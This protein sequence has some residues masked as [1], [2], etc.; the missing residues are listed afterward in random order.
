M[1]QIGNYDKVFTYANLYN[2]YYLCRNGVRWKASIQKY[3]ATLPLT[4]LNIYNKMKNRKFEKIKFYEFNIMERG[5]KRHI[6]AETIAD[7]CIQKVL[8]NKYLTPVLEPKLI[9]DNSASI[10]GKGTD[11]QLRRIKSQLAYHYK[12]YGNTGYIFQFDFSKFF[13]N[14]NHDILLRMLKKDI[15]DKDIYNYLKI[16]IDSFGEKGLGLGSQVSQIMAIYYPTM[17]DRYFKEV[18]HIK[19]YGRY[20]D[21]GY[22]I[23]KNLDE[24]KRCKDAL[25]KLSN[26]L[27]LPLN[28]KKITISRLNKTF[29]FLKKRIQL[30]D[31]GKIII[32]IDKK[33]AYKARRKL[34]KLFK[35]HKEIDT[36]INTYKTWYGLSKKYNNYYI[37][38]NYRKLFNK[39]LQNEFE[40]I[41]K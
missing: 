27:D 1:L 21:D 20:M 30:L 16:I 39:L 15:K 19:G 25:I 7:R 12:K 41:K 23:C 3:E 18:L 6:M 4:S 32:K 8:C 34:K 24:A 11:F 9:Y 38:Q 10:K 13:N 28:M 35:K 29:I 40:Y 5:K 36:L 31:S 37:S 22:A 17:I 26:Q 33:S 14:I 2:S